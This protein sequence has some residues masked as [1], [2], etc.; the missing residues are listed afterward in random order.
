MIPIHDDNPTTRAPIVT[1]LLIAASIVAFGWFQG[2]DAIERE[3]ALLSLGGVPAVI[4]GQT[5]LGA[6]YIPDLPPQASL[7]TLMF[8]HAG[9][10]HLGF[11]MLFLWIFGNNVE[12]RLGHVRFLILYLG[13]GLAGS[14]VHVALDPSSTVPIIG[15][16]GAV[17][18]ALGAYLLLYPFA[19]VRMIVPPFIFRTFQVPAWVFLIIWFVLQGVAAAGDIA[20]DS[21]TTGEPQGGVAHPVHVAGFIAGAVLLLILRPKGVVLFHRRGKAN[22]RVKTSRPRPATH[23][24]V[25]AAGSAR[26]ATPPERQATVVA[27]KPP[28]VH[29]AGRRPSRTVD[30]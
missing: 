2:L 29:H 21:V 19:R 18:G 26:G 11:N 28:I 23:G 17:S 9:W 16:S 4:T 7:V 8:L 22:Q 12:D 10:L 5:T 25:P 3:W 13:A 30:R 27:S 20:I 24:S 14:L 6:S 15:A 1:I